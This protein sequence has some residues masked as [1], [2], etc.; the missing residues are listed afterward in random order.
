MICIELSQRYS[1]TPNALVPLSQNKKVSKLIRNVWLFAKNNAYFSSKGTMLENLWQKCYL[2]LLTNDVTN[3][4]RCD[5]CCQENSLPEGIFSTRWILKIQMEY[6]STHFSPPI[7]TLPIESLPAHDSSP[8]HIN[9]SWLTLKSINVACIFRHLEP[10]ERENASSAKHFWWKL[11][12]KWREI[13]LNVNKWL[14]VKERVKHG[15]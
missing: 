7:L 6:K 15:H 14:F 4:E 8:W 2:H 9:M 10:N 1:F 5:F 13:H 12:E 3:L 11:G